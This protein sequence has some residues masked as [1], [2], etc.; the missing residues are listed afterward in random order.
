M[1]EQT[2]KSDETQ[3]KRTLNRRSIL[4]GAGALLV[5]AG[6]GG[7]WRAWDRGVF[8]A[9]EGPAFA[10]WRD[11]RT[12]SGSPGETIVRAGI[13]AASAHNTQPWIF[14]IETNRII[15]FADTSR[16]LGTFDPYLREM[17]ISLGC[18]LE[19]MVLAARANGFATDV[20][21]STGH[22]TDGYDGAQPVAMLQLTDADTD[23]SPFYDAIPDRHTNRGPYDRPRGVPAD[24]ATN[25]TRI[26][27]SNGVLVVLFEDGPER[28]TFDSAM[29][30]ATATIV[31]DRQMVH[32]SHAWFRMTPDEIDTHRDGPI[33][34]S[35]GLPPAVNV[36]A[37]MFPIGEQEGHEIW[38]E[39]TRDVHLATAPMTGIIAVRD[40]Y[41]IADNL[42]A[43]R[44]WQR[45][46]L[47]GTTQGLAMHPMNQPIEIVD[48]DRQLGRP[49]SMADRLSKL[50]GDD[51]QATFS[52]RL[53]YA[54]RI[55][56]PSPRRD[57]ADVIRNA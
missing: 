7:V 17:H 24:A 20:A 34:D 2:M 37:K 26:A 41:A 40:R 46:H 6:A 4:K 45:M 51:W 11:W 31:A 3:P 19:N 27:Q 13:L 36:L 35:F 23:R 43:G 57:P 9:S 33:I 52:F 30:D 12:A 28:G 5:V 47:W 48:R 38:K 39:T 55:A 1:I 50:T 22:L 25:L 29:N 32:D 15:L 8:S 54:E 53:G 14:R 18:A 16:H 10:P 42:A 21:M 56:H 44:A 49:A